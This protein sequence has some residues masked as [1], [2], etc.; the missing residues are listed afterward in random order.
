MGKDQA[1][2]AQAASAVP[3]TAK[4]E[5]E[6]HDRWEW[7][8]AA[9]WTPP[10]LAALESGV[11]GGRWYSLMDKVAALRTLQA[12]WKRVQANAGSHGADGMSVRSFAANAERYL[13]ELGQALRDGSYRPEPVRRVEIPKSSGGK[14]P[15]G[16]PT[17]KD[18]VVQAALKLVIE[19]IFEHEFDAAS[20]GFRPRR[21]AKDALRE[22]DGMLNEGQVWVV[23]ADLQ[24]Y[25]DSID[26]QRLLALVK[27]RI[28]DGRILG[29]I[30]RFLHQEV[31]HELQRWIPTSGTP[32][33]AVISPLLAN[34]Y[35]HELDV[36]M[37]AGGWRLVRYADDFVVL[38]NTQ[39][40]AQAALEAIRSWTAEVGL[41]LH[42]DKTHV[43]NCMLAGQGF[44]FLGYRFEAGRRWVRRKSLMA[45]RDRIRQCTR[46]T[47]GDSL[48]RIVALLN[49]VLRGWFGYFKHAHCST[50]KP[51]DAFVRRRLRSILCKRE[52]RSYVYHRSF[53]NHRRWP[54][55]YFA[56][57]GLFT[58]H[59]ARLAA[60]QPRCG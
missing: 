59:E 14:R 28:S 27:R 19:P 53:A 25:F 31:L 40:Q 1:N 55:A 52:G 12:A 15:L 4:R 21:G 33:G 30:E 57:V 48:Q 13:A 7:V 34:V 54:N 24:S 9:V 17:V 58:L 23:D 56:A 45:L 11:K 42:P 47:S 35:L 16:I 20:W 43:G 44:D 46:R 8:E 60:S 32:Q 39:E 50:F 5:A 10:M 3:E 38:C 18:R 22:V 26:H 2:A 36:R 49:P 51:I 41:T 37:R 6:T 29:L